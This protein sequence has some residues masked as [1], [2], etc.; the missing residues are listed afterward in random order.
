MRADGI[1]IKKLGD[2]EQLKAVTERLE[3]VLAS[4]TDEERRNLNELCDRNDKE[5]VSSMET[6][7]L[8]EAGIREKYF[9]MPENIKW[10][11]ADDKFYR[12]CLAAWDKMTGGDPIILFLAGKSGIGKT[13]LA[14][15]CVMDYLRRQWR[16]GDYSHGSARIFSSYRLASYYK[17]ADS[18]NPRFTREDV[19]DDICTYG[20]NARARSLIVLDEVGMDRNLADY[21]RAMLYDVFDNYEGSVILCTNMNQDEFKEYIADSIYD[22]MRGR[23]INPNTS[24][25]SQKR[26]R[27]SGYLSGK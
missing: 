3:N 7:C 14:T 10:P 20:I 9:G 22:R 5:R 19:C 8:K 27:A 13:Y 21:E 23:V 6:S 26:Q 1:K 25:V 2:S 18:F 12:T 15:W 11:E 24:Y 16:S 4:M 17:Q